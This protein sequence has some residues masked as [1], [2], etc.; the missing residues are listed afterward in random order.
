MHALA[1][2]L[3]AVPDHRRTQGRRHSLATI[4]GLACAAVAAGAKSPVAIAEWAA[5]AP[6]AVLDCFAVRPDPRGGAQVGPSATT[7]RPAPPRTPPSPPASPLA[8]WP[9]PPRPPRLAPRP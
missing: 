1:E 6:A 8:P 9:P 3:A 4:L 7:T 2:S 5:A